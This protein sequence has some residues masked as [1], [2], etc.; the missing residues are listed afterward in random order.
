MYKL[1]Q[2]SEAHYIC[3]NISHRI[4]CEDIAKALKTPYRNI[5]VCF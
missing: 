4:Q 1:G 5:S 3:N 2:M